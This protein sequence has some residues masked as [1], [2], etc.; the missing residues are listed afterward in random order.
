MLHKILVSKNGLSEVIN[1]FSSGNTSLYLQDRFSKI[2]SFRNVKVQKRHLVWHDRRLVWP[3]LCNFNQLVLLLLID[4]IR[5]QQHC[6][7]KLEM[8][9]DWGR[10]IGL[11][12]VKTDDIKIFKSMEKFIVTEVTF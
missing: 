9:A 7:M 8:L 12:F 4:L 2:K 10:E 5:K 6:K 11:L 3:F 1:T